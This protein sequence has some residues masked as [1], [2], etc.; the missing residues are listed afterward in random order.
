MI[1]YKKNIKNYNFKPYFEQYYQSLKNMYVDEIIS[2]DSFKMVRSNIIDDGIWNFVYNIRANNFDDFVKKFNK[3]KRC[4]KNRVP[5]F[6]FLESDE[7]SKY[8]DK[9]RE[10][11]NLYC[12]DSWF[13]TPLEKLNL[14][15]KAKIDVEIKISNDKQEIID[16]IME[17]FSTHDPN[18]PYGNLSPTYRESLNK[19]LFDENLIYKTYHYVAKHKGKVVS[20]AGITINGKTAY[21][22]NVTTLKGFKG[23]GISKELLS[24]IVSEL[25]NKNIQNIVFAT[26][27]GAYT[28]KYYKK[29]GFE[30][31]DYGYCFEVKE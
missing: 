12:E 25:K 1:N 15:Y 13:N 23:K 26:E 28:E 29:L 3:S 17:G 4:F 10:N 2:Y 18:D 22:N 20:I 9:L 27:T 8:L 14:N 19:K 16:C 30:V 7:S 24:F 21:L 6:Y 11:Y 31:V 5:R